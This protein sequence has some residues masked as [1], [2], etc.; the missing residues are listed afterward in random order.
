MPTIEDENEIIRQVEEDRLALSD[1]VGYEVLGMAYPG[2][3][4]NNDDR[5]AEIIKKNTEIKYSRTITST[6]NFDPQNNLY[7][8]D[9]TIHIVASWYESMRLA[10]EFISM[11]P[12]SPKIF[13]VWGHS[14]EFDYKP[15]S[16]DMLEEFCKLVSDRED[17]FY[18]TNKEILLR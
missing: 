6:H 3:G 7:R 4:Q 5:V 17:I 12:D 8:F 1:I 14:F 2:G 11:K 10:Q 15:A 18:G 16:W 13:Y 9:P